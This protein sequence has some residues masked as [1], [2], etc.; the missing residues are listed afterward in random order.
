MCPWKKVEKEA[1]RCRVQTADAIKFHSDGTATAML[2]YFYRNRK[3]EEGLV[4]DIKAVPGARVVDYG[5]H[6][7]PFCGGAKV[8]SKKSTYYWVKFVVDGG[9]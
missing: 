7:S 8:G 4:D 1:V 5:W 9:H 3:A 6:E 2:E